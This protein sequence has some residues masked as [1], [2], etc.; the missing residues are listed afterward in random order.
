MVHFL[1]RC[2]S[3]FR[4]APLTERVLT[5]VPVTDS[6]PCSAVLFI[7][8]RTAFV[9]VVSFVHQFLMLFAVLASFHG[10]PAART[11]SAPTSWHPGHQLTSVSLHNKSPAGNPHEAGASIT[12][13]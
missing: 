7:G 3:P 10:Q 4:K 11:V 8:V 12:F 9:I 1:D 6:L 2:Q 13:C 5:N